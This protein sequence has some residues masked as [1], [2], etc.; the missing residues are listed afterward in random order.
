MNNVAWNKYILVFVIT[1]TIFTLAF[2]V[3]SLFYDKRLAEIR[4]IENRVSLNFL[5]LEVERDLLA[6]LSC[7]DEY[8]S[9]TTE[10]LAALG[11]RLSYLEEQGAKKETLRD[12]KVQYSL[13]ELKDYL[14]LK[15][16]NARCGEGLHF[17]FYFYTDDKDCADCKR[18]GYVLEKLRQEYSSL[19]VYS[20][21][22]DLDI[23]GINS[24][25]RFYNL[26]REPPLMIVDRNVVYGFHGEEALYSLVGEI[27][28]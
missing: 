6:E 9:L 23:P 25:K 16:L 22:Y 19:R 28:N 12:L 7:E 1:A 20:F 2:F 8:V 26:R 24:L 17:I 27:K 5:S 21:D 18:Q 4:E 14:F 3:N 13:F 11:D 15:Q 10:D